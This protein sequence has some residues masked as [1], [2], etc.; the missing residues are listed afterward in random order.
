MEKKSSYL[1]LFHPLDPC[2]KNSTINSSSKSTSP[3]VV[4][5]F[6]DIVKKQQ[7]ARILVAIQH[8]LIFGKNTN[9]IIYL[10]KTK[11]VCVCAA[12]LKKKTCF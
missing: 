1:Q 11:T 12:I 5:M 2:K 4:E 9:F 6:A 8:V 3:S 7:Y 10:L